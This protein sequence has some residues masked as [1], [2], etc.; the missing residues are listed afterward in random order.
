MAGE[1]GRPLGRFTTLMLGMAR[2]AA[3]R[4]LQPRLELAP[5]GKLLFSTSFS[6]ATESLVSIKGVCFSP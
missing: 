3:S 6:S 2:T 5:V 1:E 4:N